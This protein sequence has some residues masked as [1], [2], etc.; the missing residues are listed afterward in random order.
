[1]QVTPLKEQAVAISLSNGMVGRHLNCPKF[2]FRFKFVTHTL[3][4]NMQQW[5]QQQK[6][7][8]VL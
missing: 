8:D 1:M 2:N 3:G 7:K 4:I 6:Q 5:Q